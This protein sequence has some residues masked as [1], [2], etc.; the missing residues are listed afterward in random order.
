MKQ[1]FEAAVEGAETD[2][3]A[4]KGVALVREARDGISDHVRSGK[5][6]VAFGNFEGTL[7]EASCPV[8]R[9][10]P[11]PRLLFRTK[12]DIGFCQCAGCETIY[13][14]PRFDE[15]SLLEIYENENFKDLSF[16]ENF[17]FENWERD[18]DRTWI[19]SNLKVQ[20]VKKYL[21]DGDRVLDVGGGVGEFCAVAAKSDLRCE[22][23]DASKQLTDIGRRLFGARVQQAE[24]EDFDPGYK[25]KGI[26]IWDVLEHLYDPVRV[27]RNC[28]RLLEPGGYLFAQVPNSGGFTNKLKAFACR[29]GLSNN[30]FKHFGFPYH[31]Y[32]FN[33][34][35]LTRL[36]AA[37]DLEAIHF[38]SWSRFM[39]D[40]KGGA[41]TRAFDSVMR[42]NCLWDYVTV[43]ARKGSS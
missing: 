8:C 12:H 18:R 37:A 11:P 5:E 26:V 13:A 35:S 15:P 19:V 16:Y 43:I 22:S 20:L 42:K 34:R 29:A 3:N 9:P 24:V 23:I 40:N 7:E 32:F 33:R 6:V 2:G 4:L 36:M 14:S 31:V 25:F 10:A 30:E 39:K 1:A 38:E 28:Y 21:H 17:S 41:L 27:L